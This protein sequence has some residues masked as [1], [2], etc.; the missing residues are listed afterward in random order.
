M[1]VKLKPKLADARAAFLEEFIRLVEIE[2][3]GNQTRTAHQV[4]IVR[5]S[6]ERARARAARAQLSDGQAAAVQ[7][8]AITAR[9]DVNSYREAWRWF[10][11]LLADTALEMAPRR[12]WAEQGIRQVPNLREAAKLLGVH[13]NSLRRMRRADLEV[14]RDHAGQKPAAAPSK[15]GSL[16]AI[17]V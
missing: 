5:S 12:N 6:L 11:R 4:G 8:L 17:A 1:L 3:R 7:A 9:V 14:A 16:P 2:L 10:D 15:G 13:R